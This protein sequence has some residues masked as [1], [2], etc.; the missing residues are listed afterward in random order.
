MPMADPKTYV[1]V[2]DFAVK[3]IFDGKHKSRVVGVMTKAAEEAVKRSGKLTL[4]KPK[5]KGAKGWSINGSLVSLGPDKAGKKLEAEVSIALATWPGKSI[6]AMPKG[7]AA[8]AID[9]PKKIDA[10]DVDAI[11]EA[12]A[13]SA[14]KAGVKYME[15]T[16]PE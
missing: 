15:G 4:D 10:G 7:S 12:A 3:D 6:K 16:K 11:A 9:D 13:Q 2:T 1:D 14:M 8:M 5:D